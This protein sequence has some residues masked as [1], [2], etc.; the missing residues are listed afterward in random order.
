[1]NTL[2]ELLAVGAEGN[3]DV[4]VPQPAAK[5]SVGP[6]NVLGG[7]AESLGVV[8][9]ELSLDLCRMQ[10]QNTSRKEER[11]GKRRTSSFFASPSFKIPCLISHA[12]LPTSLNESATVEVARW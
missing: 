4:V 12:F 1:V 11:R 10:R 9:V 2:E 5:T 3:G 6:R 8:L 7:L